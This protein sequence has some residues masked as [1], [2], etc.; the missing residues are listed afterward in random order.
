MITSR[1]RRYPYF[2]EHSALPV[3][4]P[5]PIPVP[6]SGTTAVALRGWVNSGWFKA[7]SFFWSLRKCFLQV[8]Y[9]DRH[10]TAQQNTVNRFGSSRWMGARYLAPGNNPFCSRFKTAI[11]PL[12]FLFN[13]CW[14]ILPSALVMGGCAL[15]T[16]TL[17]LEK[18][19]PV[20]LDQQA[21][22]LQA[23]QREEQQWLNDV[24][25]T[26]SGK[27][28]T[29]A[30]PTQQ[31]TTTPDITT[32]PDVT[33]T[34]RVTNTHEI[35]NTHGVLPASPPLSRL[36]P[37]RRLSLQATGL[38]LHALLFSLAAD[39]GLELVM[40]EVPDQPVTLSVQNV[41]LPTLLKQLSRQVPI[42]WSIA[43][44]RLSIRADEPYRVT[45]PIDYLNVTRQSRSS[46]GLATRVGS[47]SLNIAGD[48]AGGD[49]DNSSK[50]LIENEST[51]NFWESLKTDLNSL[52]APYGGD[53]DATVVINREAGL[54]SIR[55]H[56]QAHNEVSDYLK[57][58]TS[59]ASRQVLIEATI[60]EVTLS[61]QFQAGVD[62]QALGGN[63]DAGLTNSGQSALNFSQSLHGQP[64]VNAS[65]LNKLP[66]PSALLSAIH[67][68]NSLGRITATLD[69]LQTFGD[70]K[71]LS[72]P[73]IIAINNQSAVLKVVDNRVYFSVNVEKQSGDESEEIT[74]AT[75][76]HTVPV[77]LVMS[78]TPFIGSDNSVILNVRPTISRI[79]GFVNDPNPALSQASVVNGVPEIQV[80]EMESVLKVGDGQIAMI[81]GLMQQQQTDNES[82]VPGLSRLPGVG[83]LFRQ[84]SKSQRKTELLVFMRP[85]VIPATSNL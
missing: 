55:A 4:I 61:D 8:R 29:G 35:T 21:L 19:S 10:C 28:A 2:T 72:R 38:S 75:T 9:P 25:P 62:W 70:V 27:R 3:S 47:I 64:T 56:Q 42:I 23:L 76:I 51:H 59:S 14:I 7:V 37:Q 13:L 30:A 31:V 22:T 57:L 53:S 41:T 18:Q 40:T 58:L 46:V 20:A 67:H 85:V 54:V 17:S 24:V 68:S 71:I 11:E 65:T 79:L 81:G 16:K 50:T 52:L 6:I 69:L 78:V 15:N 77:G 32:T 82:S 1:K 36:T 5:V 12:G 26:G 44:Q 80:R 60:V 66:S 43:D 73:Q 48:S 84:R 39:I 63:T 34:H 45:Y 49:T 33:T 74:T 83:H